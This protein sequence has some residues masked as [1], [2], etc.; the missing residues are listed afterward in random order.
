VSDVDVPETRY[1]TTVDGVHIAYQVT[2]AGPV[3]FVFVNSAYISNVELA[4]EW[5]EHAAQLEWL[6]GLGRLVLFDRRGTGLSDAVSG[7]QLP[8]LEARADDIRAVMDASGFRRAVLYGLEDGAA[9]CFLFA[10]AHPERTTAIIT[11][12][13]SSRG[14]WAPEAPWLWTEDAWEQWLTEIETHWGTADF[15]AE[16][17][18]MVFPSKVNDRRFMRQYGRIVRHAMSPSA[19]VAAER[20]YRDTDVRDILPLVQAPTLVMH[21]IDDQVESVQEAR[22]IASHIPGA[23]LIEMPGSD[24]AWWLDLEATRRETNRFLAALREEEL[25]FDRVL[26]TVLFTDV[27]DSTRHAI[28]LGDRAWRDLLERHH[29]V[30]RA[31]LGRYR[32]REVDTAGD[33][34]LA[35]FDGPARAIR[36]AQAI[37]D[38]MPTIGLD[39]RAGLHTGEVETQGDD[40]RGIAVHIGARVG[41]LAAP[42]EVLV[43]Q[44]VKDLVA[45]SGLAFEDAGEHELKG[46]PDRWH[47]YRAT[48]ATPKF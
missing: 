6:A 21:G 34:F 15:T 27:V 26:A 36:C 40:I 42:S 16:L 48:Q 29:M 4:W 8:T 19:A 14:S 28:E 13:A 45:G 1:T 38:A 37:C 23:Q 35:V 2:G 7:E 32:G 22:Y 33:G 25:A 3:D 24:H 31:L 39:V 11:V 41:T 18:S 5:E 9:Q 10:A 17:T 47:L 46:V 44:T 20:M 12:G 30:V 43:S